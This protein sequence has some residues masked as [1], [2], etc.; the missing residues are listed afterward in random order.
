MMMSVI[1]TFGI[2]EAVLSLASSSRSKRGKE[3]SKLCRGFSLANV[4]VLI[5]NQAIFNLSSTIFMMVT[6]HSEDT[7][8]L[9]VVGRG[10]TP[11]FLLAAC[12]SKTHFF[13]LVELLSTFK[14]TSTENPFHIELISLVCSDEHP[15]FFCSIMQSG[16]SWNQFCPSSS[17]VFGSCC[18]VKKKKIT[19]KARQQ[20]K[21]S[22]IT[23]MSLDEIKDWQTV[24]WAYIF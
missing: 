1:N 7:G 4:G 13:C 9:W 17:A 11:L 21:L 15:A 16:K 10:W 24:M 23:W 22:D 5:N 6:W 12:C 2:I 8:S 18:D 3:G 20:H 14:K 19:T